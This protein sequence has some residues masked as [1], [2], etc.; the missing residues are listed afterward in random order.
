MYSFTMANVGDPT[1][2]VTPNALQMAVVNVVFPDPIGA[3]NATNV[4]SP[5]FSRNSAAALSRSAMSL[6]IT[7]CFMSAKIYISLR[8]FVAN[9]NFVKFVG[10]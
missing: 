4:L 8:M 1:G 2:S 3:K 7:S 9:I 5:I 6:M 10:C